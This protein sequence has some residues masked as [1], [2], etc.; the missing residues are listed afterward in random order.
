MHFRSA[1]LLTFS[2]A[3][4]LTLS[5]IFR[6]ICEPEDTCSSRTRET[7]RVLS[8]RRVEYSSLFR[9]N[10][11]DEEIAA[12]RYRNLSRISI[13]V[14]PRG[15]ERHCMKPNDP[16]PSRQKCDIIPP[17]DP[18]NNKFSYSIASRCPEMRFRS[19]AS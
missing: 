5:P 10:D 13:F 18:S 14:T 1:D 15:R 12:E 2:P 11:I 7:K 6:A 9:I 4:M 8:D 17:K 19:H 16:W 3:T